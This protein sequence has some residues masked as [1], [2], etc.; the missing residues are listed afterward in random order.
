MRTRKRSETRNYQPQ[1][2]G[3][4]WTM[5]RQDLTARC[6]LLAWPDGWELRV[7]VDGKPMLT[8]RCSRSDEAFKIAD[9]WKLHL[10]ERSWRQI[11][12]RPAAMAP[13]AD[14]RQSTH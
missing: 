6:A 9:Q 10:V 4:L 1:D 3:T 5:Q 8:E 7:L 12:P 2:V 14:P 11:V 13:Q